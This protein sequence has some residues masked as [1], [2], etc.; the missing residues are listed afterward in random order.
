ML[1]NGTVSPFHRIT[2]GEE[3]PVWT[4]S[5]TIFPSCFVSLLPV[6]THLYP[7]L[8]KRFGTIPCPC[9]TDVFALCA[10]ALVCRT[11]TQTFCRN[12]HNVTGLCNRQSCPLANSQYATVMEE[13]R[14]P[15]SQAVHK[16]PHGKTKPLR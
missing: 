11:Q 8:G 16:H 5:D 2:V 1:G 7:A 14:C 4:G 3:K 9:T 10:L 13:V 6:H 12:P 15:L